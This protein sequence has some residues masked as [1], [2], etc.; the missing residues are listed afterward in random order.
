MV[1]TWPDS[2]GLNRSWE[3]KGMNFRYQNKPHGGSHT[4]ARHFLVVVK[5]LLPKKAVLCM[6]HNS[7]GARFIS[8]QY[9]YISII[10][11]THQNH[12]ITWL[13]LTR[14]PVGWLASWLQFK[15]DHL[16]TTTY[17]EFWMSLCV[18]V[19]PPSTE[20]STQCDFY[21]PHTVQLSSPL[22]GDDLN[23]D[24]DTGRFF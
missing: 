2:G 21:G 8:L 5:M 18:H 11:Q 17:R 16:H 13:W 6:V 12:T 14:A 1:S 23:L 9:V 22:T 15:L 4:V 19:I 10:L 24:D 3:L 20:A 7:I